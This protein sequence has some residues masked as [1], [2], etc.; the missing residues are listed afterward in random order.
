[1]TES[2]DWERDG[3]DWPNRAHSRFVEAGGVRW[4][5]QVAGSGADV[6]LVHGTGAATHS[7]R[8][9]LPRLTERFRVI[10]PDL[11]GHGFSAL[12]KGDDRLSLPAM[13]TALAALVETLGAR[14]CIGVGHSA[15]A[16]ILAQMQLHNH[17]GSEQLVAINGAFLPFRGMAGTLFSPMAKV[18]G[19]NPLVP[20]WFAATAESPGTVERL[21][22]STGSVLDARGVELYRRVVSSQAH[23][24]ATLRMMASWDLQGLVDAL[25]QLQVPVVLFVAANDHAIPPAEQLRIRHSIPN[26]SYVLL[27]GLGHLAHEER[28]AQIVDQLE[29]FMLSAPCAAPA[30]NVALGRGLR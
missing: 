6:L 27:E 24:A 3:Q 16:A 17:L 30:A 1:M 2:L 5:V 4:H 12:P 8:D 21:I 23:V 25:P 18:L 14:P 28:P 9:V 7:W 13:A 29:G 15:G 26:V 10:A 11:P 20:K 19:R 22:A